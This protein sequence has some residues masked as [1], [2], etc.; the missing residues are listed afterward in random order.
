MPWLARDGK[1][2]WSRALINARSEEAASKRTWSG[3]LRRDRRVVPATSWIEWIKRGGRRLPVGIARADEAPL[4]LAAIADRFDREGEMVTA[5]S[6][7]TKAADPSIRGIHDRMPVLVP[8][9]RLGSGPVPE[10]S[11]WSPPELSVR[12]LP[13]SLNKAGY[14]SEPPEPADWSL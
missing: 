14:R 7:L 13:T 11:A 10:S 12:A 8:D 2:P 5:V 6:L 3:P 9:D 1:D 4:H